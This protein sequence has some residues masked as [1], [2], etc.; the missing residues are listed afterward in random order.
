VH[1]NY[2]NSGN[3]V[4]AFK[5]RSENATSPANTLAANKYAFSYN[6]SYHGTSGPI[7]VSFP[8]YVPE[9]ISPWI[10]AMANL[11]V[12]VPPENVWLL[13]S[14]VAHFLKQSVFRQEVRILAHSRGFPISCYYLDAQFDLTL[15]FIV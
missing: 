5:K 1:R 9:V 3:T 6:P 10:D 12:T 7:Q 15:N 2:R 14:L 11:G 13:L 8:D 4:N